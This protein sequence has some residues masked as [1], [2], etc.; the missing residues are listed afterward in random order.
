MHDPLA[1]MACVPDL[2][3]AVLKKKS[4]ALLIL[5][6]HL[7]HEPGITDDKVKSSLHVSGL[8]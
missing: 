1:L 3:A 8:L 5:L 6:W 2:D 4:R 7:K